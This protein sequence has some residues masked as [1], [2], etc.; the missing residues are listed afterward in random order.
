MQEQTFFLPPI[1]QDERETAPRTC[2]IYIDVN[3]GDIIKTK[4]EVCVEEKANG[5]PPVPLW[6]LKK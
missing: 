4:V 1:P 2:K 5:I 3:T 6:M